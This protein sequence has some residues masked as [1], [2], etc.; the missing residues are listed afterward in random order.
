MQI[1]KMCKTQNT[2]NYKIT[3]PVSERGEREFSILL[4]SCVI[5]PTWINVMDGNQDVQNQRGEN[6][7]IYTTSPLLWI[8]PSFKKQQQN[9]KQ[10][11]NK[12]K[13]GENH[14]TSSLVLPCESPQH[15][16]SPTRNYRKALLHIK[17]TIEKGHLT[18]K[19]SKT[20]N[21]KTQKW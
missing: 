11:K 13:R 18:R 20:E 3:F 10:I 9:K 16:F 21:A 17:G 14:H 8:S 4:L 1:T 6:E 5:S 15:V 7:S 2:I 12:I 19:W